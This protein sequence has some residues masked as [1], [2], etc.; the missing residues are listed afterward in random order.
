MARGITHRAGALQQNRRQNEVNPDVDNIV[1]DVAEESMSVEERM[2][3]IAENGEAVLGGLIDEAAEQ[4][5]I[6]NMGGDL[7][8]ENWQPKQMLEVGQPVQ[9]IEDGRVRGQNLEITGRRRNEVATRQRGQVATQGNIPLG[10]VKIQSLAGYMGMHGTP[11]LRNMM[12]AMGG[13][14]VMGQYIRTM[15]REIFRSFPSFQQMEDRCTE[16]GLDALG[17]VNVLAN[18]GGNGPH[19]INHVRGMMNWIQENGTIQDMSQMDMSP[20]MNQYRPRI[21]LATDADSTYVLVEE[22]KRDGAPMDSLYVYTFPGGDYCYNHERNQGMV[23]NAGNATG[24]SNQQTHAIGHET[25]INVDIVPAQNKVAN[26]LKF[27]KQN[28]YKICPTDNGPGFVKNE[29]GMKLTVTGAD[30]VISIASLYEVVAHDEQGN[31][32]FSK[33]VESVGDVDS[34]V[35]E[36][37]L[38]GNTPKM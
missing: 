20:I 14:D 16:Q 31:E 32:L 18:I 2:A 23:A 37:L 35:D 19:D 26:P 1:R 27:L 4:R 28:G 36:Y 38:G 5:A 30:D 7:R 3:E 33:C 22:R 9:A 12:R 25:K 15:G 11:E 6:Q 10:W 24:L 17:Q 8:I 29:D 34:L 13:Q 21:I